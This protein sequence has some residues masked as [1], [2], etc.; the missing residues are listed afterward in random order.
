MKLLGILLILINTAVP[1]FAKTIAWNRM[2]LESQ[3]TLNNELNLE[4][5]EENI[6]LKKGSIF[7]LLSKTE[8]S[9]V[10]LHFYKFKYSGCKNRNIESDLQVIPVPQTN[11][12]NT[13]V[14]LNFSKNCEIDIFVEMNDYTSQSLFN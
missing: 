6:T 7:T 13:E 3:Y 1:A 12:Q 4:A 14:A 10:K 2:L 8:L 11:G 9:M 5:E